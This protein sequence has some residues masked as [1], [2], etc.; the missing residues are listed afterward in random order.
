MFG[1]V[2]GVATASVVLSALLVGANVVLHRRAAVARAFHEIVFVGGIAFSLGTKAA[3]LSDGLSSTMV[4]SLE[5]TATK[6]RHVLRH[7]H[8]VMQRVLCGENVVRHV[9]GKHGPA[10]QIR[11][12]RLFLSRAPL[13]PR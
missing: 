7:I 1:A 6:M 8:L 2:E 13:A 9:P 12:V 3:F 5:G 10:A 11:H 4:T